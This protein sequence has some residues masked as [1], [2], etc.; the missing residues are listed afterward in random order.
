MKAMRVVVLGISIVS[1][2]ISNA[3]V[4]HADPADPDQ[5]TGSSGAGSHFTIY[6]AYG[7]G[8]VLD[9]SG[10]AAPAAGAGLTVTVPLVRV[11]AIELMGTT[12]YALGHE[13][14]D[15]FW[16]R[17][18]IGL[19]LED[20]KRKLRPY[21]ALR[22]VHLHYA[23]AQTWLDHPGDSIAGS[24]SEGLQ[25]RSGMAAA[26]GVSWAIPRTHDKLR[27]MAEAEL[28][29]VPIGTGP[30]WFLATTVGFG[31]AF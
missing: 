31:C 30:E 2:L 22:F 25:H 4:A 18:A 27:V 14:E 12:G 10:G 11:L 9:K 29:W 24:S 15:D 23:P 1:L 8:S 16:A 28:A 5:H 20:S 17:L 7:V 13:S 3:H 21:G 19:R 26:A 6:A